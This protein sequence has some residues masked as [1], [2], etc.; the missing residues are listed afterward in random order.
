[1]MLK[2]TVLLLASLTLSSATAVAHLADCEPSGSTC[3]DDDCCGTA[4]Y[5]GKSDLKLCFTKGT[6]SWVNADDNNLSYTVSNCPAA[7]TEDNSGDTT[8]ETTGSSALAMSS[9]A[10]L[11]VATYLMA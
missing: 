4:S 5:T 8:E 9:L 2:A 3:P 11:S 6:S 7:S 1:M 10:V